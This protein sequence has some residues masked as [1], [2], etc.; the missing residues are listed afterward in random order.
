MLVALLTGLL[1]FSPHWLLWPPVSRYLFAFVCG[2]LIPTVGRAWTAT[3]PEASI[4]RWLL[5]VV[6]VFLLSPSVLGY[7]TQW[8]ALCE[9]SAAAVL[10]SLVAYRPEHPAFAFLGARSMRML[11]LISGSYYVLHM[12]TLHGAVTIAESLIPSG[13]SATAPALVGVLVLSVWLAALAPLMWC[14]YHLV[15]AP[16]I[17]L[18]R[19]LKFRSSNH[20]DAKA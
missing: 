18:G 5:G 2:M 4:K 16:G 9:T 6:A 12:L 1:S 7:Y 11:G 10:V 14:S 17:A 8:S 15:E 3:L 19:R 20:M 13:W